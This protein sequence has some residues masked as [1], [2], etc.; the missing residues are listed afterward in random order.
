MLVEHLRIDV[1]EAQQFL[2][3]QCREQ[4]LFLPDYIAVSS[5]D[6]RMEL[7]LSS[8]MSGRIDPL[9]E[10][11]FIRGWDKE[12]IRHIAY[13]L[14]GYLARQTE[15]LHELVATM[16]ADHPSH[17]FFLEG[18]PPSEQSIR[19]YGIHAVAMSGNADGEWWG[20]DP[21]IKLQRS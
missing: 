12:A 14:E 8:G 21:H 20:R 4:G 9:L 5:V 15:E 19:L 6:Y 7:M 13:R 10:Y 11:V 16:E 18:I 17:V 3:S 1:R 2:I